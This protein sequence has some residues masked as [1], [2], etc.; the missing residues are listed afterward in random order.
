MTIEEA[1]D[2][3]RIDAPDN[4]III[5][6][7]LSAIPEY[8]EVKTG[9]RWDD[10]PINPLAKTTAGFILQLWFDPESDESWRLKKTIDSLL[11]ALTSIWR[12]KDE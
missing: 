8:L 3:L 11:S 1:R 2:I 7:L 5:N 10:E 9:E 6:H 4:D 12:G